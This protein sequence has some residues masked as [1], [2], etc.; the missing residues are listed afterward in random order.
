MKAKEK[1]TL[2]TKKTIQKLTVIIIGGIKK[3][4]HAPVKRS[5]HAMTATHV[6]TS[7]ILLS[8]SSGKDSAWTL[9]QLLKNKKKVVKLLTTI[10]ETNDRVAMHST[11]KSLLLAQAENLK[12]PVELVPLPDQ[13]INEI[14]EQRM[15]DALK[16][17]SEEGFT[18]IAFGDLFLEDLRHYR[19]RQMKKSLQFGIEMK[20]LFPIWK[21]DTTKLA[22]DMLSW[23][24]EAVIT[25]VDAEKI[26]P[27]Y[28]GCK[29][30]HDFL[31][32]AKTKDIDLC[33]EKGEF[34]TFV[35]NCP[36]FKNPL[37]IQKGKQE[38]KENF[39]FRDFYL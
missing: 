16:K 18:E 6:N 34:H 38:K 11:R 21:T 8:W 32:Y 13:C 12:L 2:N 39:V 35:F 5:L 14:Y 7:N 20:A 33:G 28:C 26:D 4:I 30:D 3:G 25:C 9:H 22:Y 17:L 19:E 10:N 15:T 1:S 24:L 31:N 27:F 23:G 37:S 36:L 29:F